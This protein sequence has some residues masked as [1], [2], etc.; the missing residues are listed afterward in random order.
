ME[1]AVREKILE[2][3]STV[4]ERCKTEVEK[5][6]RFEDG[7]SHLFI[8]SQPNPP[9]LLSPNFLP[10]LSFVLLPHLSSSLSPPPPFSSPQIKRPYFHVKPLERA[11]LRNWREYLDFE[12]AEGNQQRILILF[13]RCMVACAL[14]EDFWIKVNARSTSIASFP[15]SSTDK[16]TLT[17]TNNLGRNLGQ[18]YIAPAC[19]TVFH[20]LIT[21]LQWYTHAHTPPSV[22]KVC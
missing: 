1:K 7:V 12:I 15:G 9:P 2:R 8:T 21:Y 17:T 19:D 11:Q 3:R 13:E 6:S 10:L 14:Y 18:G 16:I 22:C 20:N 5:R 4:H